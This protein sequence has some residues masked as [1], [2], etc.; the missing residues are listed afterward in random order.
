[1]GFW[2]DLDEPVFQ[3]LVSLQTCLNILHGMLRYRNAFSINLGDFAH[4]WYD[5]SIG[6]ASGKTEGLFN[7]INDLA[8][9]V[10]FQHTPY[11]FY[12]VVFAVVRW[13]V[14]QLSAVS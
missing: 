2:H 8:S 9:P 6:H 13:V 10:I 14:G 11:S 12:R 5:A 4:S 7:R 1:M 3:F